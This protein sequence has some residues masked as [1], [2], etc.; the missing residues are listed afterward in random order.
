MRLIPAP[1][2]KIVSGEII[3]KGRDLL[4]LSEKEMQGIRGNSISMIFQEPMTS[5]NPVFKIGE[6]IS[7]VYIN[8][9]KLG[10]KDSLEKSVEILKL[11]GNPFP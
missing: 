11:V 8:H 7:E 1:P 6:Q 2:G 4:K 3:F 10:K 5:L 9:H